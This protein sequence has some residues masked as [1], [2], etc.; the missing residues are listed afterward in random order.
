MLHGLSGLKG[1]ESIPI[2]TCPSRTGWQPRSKPICRGHSLLAH[3][4]Q[5]DRGKEGEQTRNMLP[6]PSRGCIQHIHPSLASQLP[7]M[8]CQPPG[9]SGRCRAWSC[10]FP[11][12]KLGD[13]TRLGQL[14]KKI[15]PRSICTLPLAQLY[16]DSRAWRPGGGGGKGK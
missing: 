16:C 2:P 8:P 6:N 4:T 7:F 14:V 1:C 5:T 13:G 11:L 9:R 3:P 10:S 15:K 12:P